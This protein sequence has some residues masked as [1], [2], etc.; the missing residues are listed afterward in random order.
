M[1]VKRKCHALVYYDGYPADGV[2]AIYLEFLI[3][4]LSTK[5]QFFIKR[6]QVN[7]V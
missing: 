5:T 4:L 2:S 7:G 1:K 3:S 6:F